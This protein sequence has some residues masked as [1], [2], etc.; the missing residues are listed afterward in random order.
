MAIFLTYFCVLGILSAWRSDCG[1]GCRAVG[2]LIVESAQDQS[3]IGTAF[4]L[5]ESA[6]SDRLELPNMRLETEIIVPTA[7]TMPTEIPS[8]S[9]E[10]I[11]RISPDSKSRGLAL[12]TRRRGQPFKVIG[13]FA[14]M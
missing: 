5:N 14:T 1:Q 2:F 12:P 9:P 13:P 6:K 3:K 11:E 10:T 4:A 7:K 8:T